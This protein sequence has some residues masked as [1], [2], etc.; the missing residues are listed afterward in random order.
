[1]SFVEGNQYAQLI[2]KPEEVRIMNLSATNQQKSMDSL[3]FRKIGGQSSGSFLTSVEQTIILSK[4]IIQRP[5]MQAIH[6][7]RE[8]QAGS[9]L[10]RE[11][12]NRQCLPLTASILASAVVVG[13]IPDFH[14]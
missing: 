10:C 1:M 7:T 11:A 8:S 3:K 6:G 4:R 5:I 2:L 14:R 12:E 13:V 9:D